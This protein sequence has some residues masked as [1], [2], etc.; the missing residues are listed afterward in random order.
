MRKNR[1]IQKTHMRKGALR[2]YMLK[3]YGSKAFTEKGTIKLEYLND[4][5]ENGNS[6]ARKMAQLA[7]N[8]RKIRS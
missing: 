6:H 7:K 1:W 2:N 5:I 8:L 3:H 4:V